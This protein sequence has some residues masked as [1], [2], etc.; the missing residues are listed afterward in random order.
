MLATEAAEDVGEIG[1]RIVVGNAE[2]HRA[3][4]ALARQGGDGAGF[5][6]HDAAGEVD[7]ALALGRQPRAPALLDEQGAAELL[8]EPA[9][10]HRHGRLGLVNPL[11]GL[12]EG[13]R[14]RR[15]PGTS[16]T[17]RCRASSI[18]P[19]SLSVSLQTFVRPI[20]R[21][22]V[23]VRHVPEFGDGSPV[24]ILAAARRS[25]A[26]TGSSRPLGRLTMLSFFVQQLSR[27]TRPRR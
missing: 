16:A 8:L 7:Q 6:L 1:L 13:A 5:D 24:R 17:D 11:G 27:V 26:P 15:W 25:L 23:A 21:K 12:G 18:H 14:C 22:A 20:N 3:A 9:H 10:V 19:N 2:P 4:Q